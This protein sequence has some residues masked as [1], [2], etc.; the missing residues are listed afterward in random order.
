M[1]EP[2]LSGA[3]GE[4]LGRAPR[5]ARVSGR[6]RE[7]VEKWLSHSQS[8]ARANSRRRASIVTVANQ[9]QHILSLLK[10]A[11]PQPTLRVILDRSNVVWYIYVCTPTLPGGLGVPGLVRDWGRIKGKP[12]QYLYKKPYRFTAYEEQ[13]KREDRAHVDVFIACSFTYR[14]ATYLSCLRLHA[15]SAFASAA[16]PRRPREP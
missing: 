15:V 4:M 16:L 7:I 12:T 14:A 2:W 3:A 10:P 11:R 1:R 8:L 6:S 13:L 9:R 5:S